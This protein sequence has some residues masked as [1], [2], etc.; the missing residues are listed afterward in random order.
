[1]AEEDL[2]G[3][4]AEERLKKL[5]ELKEK[6]KKEIEEAEKLIKDSNEELT[7][8]D[9]WMRKVPIPQVALDNLK[10]LSK[11]EKDI[12][13]VHKG[14]KEKKKDEDNPE[15][16]ESEVEID[17]EKE[18]LE[19]L[20]RNAPQIPLE[21]LQ[22][23]YA[24]KLSQQ[25]MEKLYHEMVNL[26]QK[27]EDKG[28]INAEEEK[29]V[30]YMSAAVEKKLEDIDEGKYS[31]TESVALAASVTK[32]VGAKLRGLYQSERSDGNLYKS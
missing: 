28:Y 2:K 26:N 7:G 17:D 12:L 21:M 18:D 1:M 23:E 22:S 29:R 19:S 13:K 31:F 15:D 24:A 10:E 30:Q 4:P 5:K 11:E 14:L 8:K 32:Q 6:K 16:L 20:T 3:L 25:P 27:V 9:N